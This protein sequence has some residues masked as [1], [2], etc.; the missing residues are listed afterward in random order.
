ME[1]G[2]ETSKPNPQTG[3][4]VPSTLDDVRLGKSPFVTLAGDPSR[5]GQTVNMGSLTY[6]SPID[7]QSYT[8]PNVTGYVHD[9]GSA[10]KGRPDKL[11]VATGDFRGWSPQA[12]SAL[13]TAD[14][15]HRQVTPLS[16][17]DADR[18]LRP[19]GMP[20]PWRATGTGESPPDD[21]AVASGPP[22]PQGRKMPGSLMDMFQPRDYAGNQIGI[23]DAIAQNSNSL[24]GLG[25]GLMSPRNLARGDPTQTAAALQ[26]FQ[27][28][29]A[30]DARRGYQQAQLQHQQRQEAFQRSQASQQQANWERQFGRE[31]EV[32]RTMRA[33]GID[34]A[35]PEGR[36][37]LYP[38]TDEWKEGKVTYREQD[39]PYRANLRTGQYEWGPMGPPPGMGA[40][41]GSAP[42]TNPYAGGAAVP[43]VGG[44]GVP[45]A[46]GAWPAASTPIAGAQ[47]AG[48][49]PAPLPGMENELPSVQKAVR[50]KQLEEAAKHATKDPQQEAAAKQA[51]GNVLTALDTA[52]KLSVNQGGFL[53][54]TGLVG[55]ALK[56][57]YQPSKDLEKTLSTIKANVSLDKLS[58]MRA[59]STTGAS[60]L[61]AVTESEH[62]LLQASIAALDQEQSPEQFKANL[63][64]VRATYEWIVNRTD[65]N[66][67]PPF[68]LRQDPSQS[69]GGAGGA[70]AAGGRT[71][72]RDPSGRIVPQ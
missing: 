32:L 58:A 17:D 40:A 71:F 14:A 29:S 39:Y 44:G 11:D 59:A 48:T 65:A 2:F 38:K 18:A 31:P 37:L 51:A 63:K 66:Q 52:E 42:A 60:G 56:N 3:K 46:S 22:P 64:R 25:M 69:V 28:G 61:G 9:T 62:Q 68:S 7:R 43:F 5:Y 15:G 30:L 8:L 10:F 16:G 21:T 54:T 55:G 72:I 6:T 19:I 13:V 53:P 20:E 67:P 35:S 4:R 47:S 49:I 12:A 1:G 23:G 57:V 34:P 24:I 50:Q 36:A 41:G 27:T 45:S 70:G 33:T 26:G